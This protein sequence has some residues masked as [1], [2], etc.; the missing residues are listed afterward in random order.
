MTWHRG[1][2]RLMPLA[3]FAVNDTA[4]ELSARVDGQLID[5]RDD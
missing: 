3:E 2:G 1:P 5:R 4:T